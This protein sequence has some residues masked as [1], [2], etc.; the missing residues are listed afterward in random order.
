MIAVIF[1]VEPAEGRSNEYFDRA[2]DL[3][4]LLETMDGF[5][6]IE[7]FRSLANENRYLSLSF[8]R[9]EASVAAWRQTEEHRLA[10]RDGRTAIFADYRLRIASVIR[11]YGLRARDEA[12]L[13]ARVYH[14]A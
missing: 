12:P 6:S 3:K 8:W 13:D 7:R 10:Q 5:I 4:P 11:D 14:H 2:A 1:E 9:D